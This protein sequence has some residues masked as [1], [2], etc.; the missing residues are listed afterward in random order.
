MKKRLLADNQKLVERF[1]A[2]KI[3]SLKDVPDF[4]A[5]KRGLIYSHRDFDKFYAALKK[6]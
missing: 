6:G 1:G 4:Y 5:F 2:K 3:S